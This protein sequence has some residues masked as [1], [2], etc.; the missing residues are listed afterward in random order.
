[1]GSGAGLPVVATAALCFGVLGVAR[2]GFQPPRGDQWD[3]N[4]ADSLRSLEGSIGFLNSS[5]G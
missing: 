5:N 2:A 1:M 4:Q 3:H